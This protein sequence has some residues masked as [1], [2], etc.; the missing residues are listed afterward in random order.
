MC[1][2]DE[3]T[4]VAAELGV[5]SVLAFWTEQFDCVGARDI[6]LTDRQ[7]WL[8]L[9]EDSRAPASRQSPSLVR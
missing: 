4:G 2:R 5:V 3:L 7:H 6:R 1:M 9:T 8:S